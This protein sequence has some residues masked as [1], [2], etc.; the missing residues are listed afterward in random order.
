VTS[1]PDLVVR[2]RR[3]VTANGIG[4]HAI[5]VR[6][7]VISK[8]AAF[9]Q[10]PSGC[11]VFEAGDSVVMPGLVDTHVHINEPG[12]TEWEGFTTATRAAAAGGVT[13]IIEMPLNSIPPTTSVPALEAKLAAAAGQ[14]WVDVGFWGGL[15]PG[16]VAE[17]AGLRRAGVFGFKCFL[18]HSG[19][20]EFPQVG[21]RDLREGLAELAALGAVLLVHAELPAP[22][23]EAAAGIRSASPRRYS[24]WLKSRPRAAENDA[25]ALLVALS[26]EFRARIHVVHLSSSEAIATLREARKEGLP[27]TVETCPHYLCLSAE[28]I[29]DGRTEFKCAPPIRE[30]ENC[31]RLWDALAEGVI[32]LV[33]SDHS[34]CPAGMKCAGDGDFLRAWGGISSLQTGLPAMW[35]AMHRRGFTLEH[36]VQWMCRGPAR[37]AGLEKRKGSIAEGF[38][39][40]L[41]VWN[42]EQAFR[43]D[44]SALHHQ[45]KLT[46]YAHR[47][48]QGVVVA[49]FL[50]GAKIYADQK[51]SPGPGGTV[52]KRG[53]S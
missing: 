30:Q 34:P 5:H 4:P 21:G 23:E 1:A 31:E 42:P 2:G 36:L 27:I 19:V 3:V 43:V 44:P 40:D 53:D 9:G 15:V 26:R 29:P 7:G 46:P 39:A 48:L 45:L 20:A 6:Q 13:T 8:V 22:I 14:L 51:F 18:V 25:I 47:Q 12:R 28:E 35:S 50:R 32:D 10:P 16:N 41:V 33:V 52:L 11:P 38:D 24:T 17:L 37:L 49:T